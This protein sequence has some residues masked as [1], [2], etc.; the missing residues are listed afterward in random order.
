MLLNQTDKAVDEELEAISTIYSSTETDI[1]YNE[2]SY[3][4]LPEK[5]QKPPEK[6]RRVYSLDFE[7]LMFRML[8]F[9]W[10]YIVLNEFRWNLIKSFMIIIEYKIIKMQ[11]MLKQK[12]YIIQT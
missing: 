1:R 9:S 6:Q 11:L 10:N 8:K 4:Y 12:K 7:C 2:S 3:E 5:L